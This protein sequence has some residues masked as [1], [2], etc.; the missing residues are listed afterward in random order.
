MLFLRSTTQL[1]RRAPQSLS[2]GS[3]GPFAHSSMNKAPLLLA[4][5]A[6]ASLALAGDLQPQLA[7]VS[8]PSET[9]DLATLG[10][11][12]LWR[13]RITVPANTWQFGAVLEIVRG[14]EPVIA[15]RLEQPVDPAKREQESV[16]DLSISLTP[17]NA[18]AGEDFA[19]ARHLVFRTSWGGT[20]S[21]QNPFRGGS[22]Q[23]HVTPTKVDRATYTLMTSANAELRLRII[24]EEAK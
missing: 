14:G 21:C 11:M 13:F 6:S 4:L 18:S 1:P 3:L 2:L 10:G 9:Y 17:L 23:I 12:R 22:A 5:V 19:S 16:H 15:A 24:P 20:E 8:I 7:P